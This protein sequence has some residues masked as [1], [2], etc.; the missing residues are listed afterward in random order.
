MHFEG[1]TLKLFQ[2]TLILKTSSI[3]KV[4]IKNFFDKNFCLRIALAKTHYAMN[5]L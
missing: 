3:L 1:E 2:K 5:F 4:N